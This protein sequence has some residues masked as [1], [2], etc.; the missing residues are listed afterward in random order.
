MEQITILSI[1]P[2]QIYFLKRKEEDEISSFKISCTFCSIYEV[3]QIVELKNFL[4]KE[5]ILLMLPVYYKDT[6]LTL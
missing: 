4:T 3:Q 6:P 1:Q 2:R 5:I